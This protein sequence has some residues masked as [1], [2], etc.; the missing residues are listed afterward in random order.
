MKAGSD[1]AFLDVKSRRQLHPAVAKTEVIHQSM[2]DIADTDQN[3]FIAAVHTENN[4]YLF[5]QNRDIITVALLAEFTEAAEI[6]PDLGRRQTE[7]LSE[8]RR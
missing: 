7:L 5:A 3:G 1:Q 2:P 8:F 4:R 6:L